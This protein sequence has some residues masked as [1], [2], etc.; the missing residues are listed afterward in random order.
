MVGI[1]IGSE[2]ELG[3]LRKNGIGIGSEVEA[4]LRI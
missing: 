3:I 4:G 1:A 2:V